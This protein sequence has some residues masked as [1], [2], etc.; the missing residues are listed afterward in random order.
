MK[1]TRRIDE[2]SPMTHGGP[3]LLTMVGTVVF[4][5]AACIVLALSTATF[6]AIWVGRGPGAPSDAGA[7]RS[8]RDPDTLV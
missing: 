1:R 6:A 5:F 8:P 4:V 2:E 7:T 3:H